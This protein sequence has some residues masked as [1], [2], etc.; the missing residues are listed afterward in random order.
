MMIQRDSLTENMILQGRYEVRKAIHTTQVERDYEVY[1]REEKKE[2][3]VKEFYPSN[4][5]SRGADGQTV[6]V[7]HETNLSLSS[8]RNGLRRPTDRLP[9]VRKQRGSR[10]QCACFRKI[11]R[12][13]SF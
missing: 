6:S 5:C 4:Y 12:F 2:Y 8:Q 3:R 13:M 7:E 9:P 10:K 11:I 1:D